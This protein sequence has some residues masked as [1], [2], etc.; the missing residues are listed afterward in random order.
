MKLRVNQFVVSVV[1]AV[2]ATVII[3]I[4]AVS[5]GG[6]RLD[7]S[8]CYYFVYYTVRDNAV[9]AGSVSVA[10]TDYGGAGYVLEYDNEFYVTVSAYYN[11]NEADSVCKSLKKRNLDCKVLEVCK[12]DYKIAGLGKNAALY[13]GN[14]NTLHSLSQMAYECAN[15]LDTGKY[16][17][18][19]VKSVVAD[20]KTG[21]DS[22][23]SANS[24]NCFFEELKRL[25]VICND[26]Y[27]GTVYSKNLRALQIAV[28]DTIIN[29]KLY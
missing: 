12:D 11:E 13:K 23:I 22:L 25:S 27:G 15:A 29:I 10:V 20:I 19:A 9:S 16:G 28:C 17:Q 18:S 14:L 6:R 1:A 3:C 4:C 7:F 26:L 5:C 8:A 21:L 2:S 24:D